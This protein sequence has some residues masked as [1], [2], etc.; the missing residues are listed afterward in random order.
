M[1]ECPKLLSGLSIFGDFMRSIFIYNKINKKQCLYILHARLFKKSLS[2]CIIIRLLLLLAGLERN[3]GPSICFCKRTLNKNILTITCQICSEI[4]H[5]TCINLTKK[6]VEDIGCEYVCPVCE[7]KVESLNDHQ[8]YLH[9]SG[10]LNSLQNFIIDLTSNIC[11]NIYQI[12][13]NL[14]NLKKDIN[15]PI[16][17]NI[18]DDLTES[19]KELGNNIESLRHDFNNSSSGSTWE[20]PRN[21]AK[22]KI[23]HNNTSFDTKTS[24][25]FD[26]FEDFPELNSSNSGRDY[27]SYHK[28]NYN[29]HKD[30]S[31][32]QN[33]NKSYASGSKSSKS[34]SRFTNKNKKVKLITDS[35]YRDIGSELEYRSTF[36]VTSTVLSGGGI[37]DLANLGLN[38]ES[39]E[40][41]CFI[42]LG[43]NNFNYYAIRDLLTELFNFLNEFKTKCPNKTLIFGSV[44]SRIDVSS[45]VIAKFNYEVEKY[46]KNHDIM[47]FNCYKCFTKFDYS[48]DGIHLNRKGKGRLGQL[49]N[50]FLLKECSKKEKG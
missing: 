28:P 26:I 15:N 14:C 23:S 16:S 34:K 46:C 9:I 19:V 35:I 11:D 43:G 21:F 29:S 8:N 7:A 1:S 25:R 10:V 32:H 31:F 38:L 6:E 36:N 50:S 12:N 17:Q 2:D 22:T 20:K 40:T 49:L 42:S 47:F 30:R 13:E 24:N 33:N 18:N 3:P 5:N 37:F 48:S 44:I 45:N 41:T 4:Y 39:P 27:D